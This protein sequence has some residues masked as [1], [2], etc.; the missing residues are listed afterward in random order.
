MMLAEKP[1]IRQ[2]IWFN[3]A[4]DW[5][6]NVSNDETLEQIGAFIYFS[7]TFPKNGKIYGEI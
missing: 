5:K 2:T 1:N 7:K 4:K 3:I 6:I